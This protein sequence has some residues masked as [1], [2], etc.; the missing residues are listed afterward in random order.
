MAS[1]PFPVGAPEP[2]LGSDDARLVELSPDLLAV[3]G[4]DGVV[5][6]FNHA[7]GEILPWTITGFD[8]E[9]FREHLHED[10]RLSFETAQ[11]SLL[12]GDS[13][14][15]VLLRVHDGTGYREIDWRAVCDAPAGI[16]AVSGRDVTE[17]NRMA[18]ELA[19]RAERL[20]RTNA[21]LQEFAYVASHDLSE[22]LRMVTSYLD[23]I[24]RRYDEQLDDAGR[25]FIHF[26]VDGAQRMRALIDDLL[27]YSRVGAAEVSRED[28]DLDAVLATVRHDL[29]A[30]LE[31]AGAELRSTALGTVKGDP[32]QLGQLLQNLVANAVKFR[33]ARPP[34]VVVSGER[35]GDEYRLR[36]SDNGIGIDPRHLSRIF[37]VFTRLHARDEYPGT[38]IGLSICRRIAERHGGSIA[39]ESEPGEGT[40]FTVTLPLTRTPSPAPT[41]REA[42]T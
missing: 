11:R 1:R 3:V 34:V 38:G 16:F 7:W 28:V 9:R 33:G 40:M 26:A 2:P 4:L 32:I 15:G 12:R 29:A 8:A 30:A 27:V 23:L 18:R 31:D 17:A 41:D 25:E 21:D 5:R 13:V 36:V 37:Q 19:L 10:D 24:E 35:D 39:V 42:A 6:R 20:E 22:P 14:S